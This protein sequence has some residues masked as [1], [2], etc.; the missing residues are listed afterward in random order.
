MKLKQIINSLLENDLYKWSMGMCIFHQ[1][2]EKTTTW[3]FKCRNKDVFFTSEMVEEIKEQI[4]AYC[5]LRYTEDELIYLK[6]IKWLKSSYIDYLRLWHPRYEDFTITTDSECGLAISTTGSWLN[7]SVYEVPTLAIVSEVYYRMQYDYDEL[8]ENFKKELENKLKRI[9]PHGG[10]CISNFS[11]FGLR[12][13]L[14]GEAQRYLVE[15]LK[16]AKYGCSKFIGTSNV[17]LAK[18]LEVGYCGTMAHE[19]VMSFQGDLKYNPAYSNALMMDAWIKEYGVLNGIALTDTI[20]TDCFLKDFNLTRASLFAGCRHDSGCPYEWSEKM[21]KQYESLGIDPKT[22]TLLYSDSL[23]FER[24]DKLFHTYNSRINTAFGIGGYL[25]NDTGDLAK[26]LNIV[27]KITKVD[28]HDC[29]KI[30]DTPG[31]GICKNQEYIEYLQRCIKW[32]MEN[33]K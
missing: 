3:E 25:S 20:T 12:R 26:P 15:K 7:A 23:D 4:E 33:D 31:K 8:F 29:A 5:N 10:L 17:F 21:I 14:S 13:R 16:N 1:F 27:M 32:R 11:E 2:S 30:S 9:G 22:K 6:N 18:E 24:A 28:G 19:F